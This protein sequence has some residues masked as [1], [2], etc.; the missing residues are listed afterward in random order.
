MYSN[1]SSVGLEAGGGGDVS[2]HPPGVSHGL[3]GNEGN[4]YFYIHLTS[5]ISRFE[6]VKSDPDFL[7]INLLFHLFYFLL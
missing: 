6:Q 4:P 5:Y 7:N 3:S 2:V 1:V